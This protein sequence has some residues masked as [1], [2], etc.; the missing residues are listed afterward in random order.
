MFFVD[1]RSNTYQTIQ[2]IIS[3]SFYDIQEISGGFACVLACCCCLL[4]N[5]VCLCLFVLAYSELLNL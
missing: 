1:V 4:V 3:D 5:V 2:E